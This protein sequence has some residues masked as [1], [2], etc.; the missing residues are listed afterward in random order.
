MRVKLYPLHRI[1]RCKKC[2]KNCSYVCDYVTDNDT[3]TNFVTGKS[4]KINYQV[5]CD[6]RCIVYL[7]TCKLCQK[8]YT[9]ENTDDFRYRWSNY[10]SNSRKFDKKE[11]CLEEHL[12]RHFSSLGH[13]GFLN[14]LSA[15]LIDK[16]NG[17]DPKKREDY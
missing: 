7:L 9:G 4:F 5:N 12:Y 16:T 11:S 17:S 8:Q 13:R 14:D 6:G 1:V 10:K 3:F 15:T 2:A